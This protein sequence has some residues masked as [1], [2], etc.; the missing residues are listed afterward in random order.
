VLARAAREAGAL[1]LGFVTMPFDCEGKRRQSTAREGLDALK[2]AADGVICL[3]SQKLFK[4]IDEST[5]VLDTFKLSAQMLADGIAGVWRL[6]ALKG[7]LPIHY[8]ELCGL[9]RDRHGESAF[10]VAEAAGLTR[11]AEAI[12]KLLAH[13][14]LDG[15]AALQNPDAVLV[16]I[17]GGPDLKMTE[18][19]RVSEAVQQYCEHGHVLMGA[20]ID[21]SFRDR[22][23]VTLIAARQAEPAVTPAEFP[24]RSSVSSEELDTQLL[25]NVSTAR[26]GS[27]FVPPPPALLPEKMQQ[28]L[29]RQRGTSKKA[30]TR[31]RQTQLPLDIVSKGRFDKSEPT[32]HR[33]EDLDVPTYIRRGVALN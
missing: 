32:I 12:E 22:L 23:S 4:L 20:A 27:R 1:V 15:A 29:K 18:I 11:A 26:P 10:A 6:L 14:L 5:S 19:S 16:S 31:M 24:V 2:A 28:M 7:L 25:S 8:S 30:S 21:E 13:P 3:P 17:V 33:G 9:L